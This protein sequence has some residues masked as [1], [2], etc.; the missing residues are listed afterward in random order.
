MKR[1]F[2]RSSVYTMSFLF[3]NF[4]RE[5]LSIFQRIQSRKQLQFLL[6]KIIAKISFWKTTFNHLGGKLKEQQITKIPD[7]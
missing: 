2:L 7:V 3:D 4:K 6:R 5:F 1:L